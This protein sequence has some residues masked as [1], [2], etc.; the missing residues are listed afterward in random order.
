MKE[1]L[2]KRRNAFLLYLFACFFPV[3]TDLLETWGFALLIGSIEKGDMNYFLKT[4][5]LC[6][7]LGFFGVGL[8]ITSRF[9]RIG[10]MRDTILDVRLKAFDKILKHS[11]E[12]FNK[13]SKEVYISN[14][15]NDINTFEQN[16]FLKLLNVI[17]QG[18]KYAISILILLF[19]DAKFA[20]ATALI[21]L[22]V[23]YLTIQF[24]KRTIKLQE[25]VSTYNEQ[26]T[27]DVSNTLNGLEILKLNQVEDKFLHNTLKAIDRVER[28]K[29][30]FAVFTEGQRGITRFLSN[31]VFVGMMIYL[32]T[33]AF[34][35]VSL[36]RI[37]LL[38]QLGG[39]C[40]W[41]IGYV[42]P[43]F[44]ELKASI[45]IYDKITKNSADD[46]E[47]SA[48]IADYSFSKN[49]EAKNLS[50]S[51]EGKT[52]LKNV[53]FTLEKGKKYLIKG[54]SGAGK[55]TLM[56]L[57]SGIYQN[58]EG[59]LLLDGNPYSEINEE[60]FNAHIAFIYQN[61]FLFEDT[62]R[63]NI[64]LFKPSDPIQMDQV[65]AKS[66]LREFI[67][68]KPLGLDELL[69]ENGKNLSGGQRQR[70]SIA[71]AIFKD[72]DILFVD[73]GTSSLNEEL[74]RAVE[75]TLLSLDSTVVAISHRYYSGITEQ[76]D[77]VLE[78]MDG[79]VIQYSS[80]DYFEEVA[81]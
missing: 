41:P 80:A 37:A 9:M 46:L 33:L 5:A 48:R 27:V 79:D 70:V 11:Y 62:I 67:D 54:P 73:E 16:F 64:S 45:A 39:G 19:L 26:F 50:F 75:E 35:G 44:N 30:H 66:G 38:L 60:S 77:Y 52:I 36:T 65:I 10:Y 20:L 14:L 2:L 18:G 68:S 72:A 43:M 17:Y 13:Q 74:G 28:K 69:M 49:I 34:D 3:F 55:S 7:V 53:N 78:I 40:I 1:L 61:V 25:Q 22:I 23:Y 71:R 47:Q 57:L 8:F 6:V 42:I 21:S 51:Y 59:S 12:N 32:L 56:K 58:H 31:F 76:Y 15:I 4:M 81:V 29:L 63:N 24:E